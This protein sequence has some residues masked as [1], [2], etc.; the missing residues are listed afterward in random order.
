MKEEEESCEPIP[1]RKMDNLGGHNRQDHHL[2]QSW[3]LPQARLSFLISAMYDTLPSPQ[4]LHCWYGTEE[5]CQL[6][7]HLSPSLQHILSGCK[8]EVE[9]GCRGFNGT[10]TQ[11]FLKTLG[12]RGAKLQKALK[13]LAEEAEKGQGL[14]DREIPATAPPPRDVPGLKEQEWVAPG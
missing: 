4:N 2:G 10:S 1:A 3:K 13:D 8:T 7:G 12:V 9:V 14:G 11:R 5:F 6:C